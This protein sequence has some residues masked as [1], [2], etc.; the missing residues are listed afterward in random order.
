MRLEV[1]RDATAS[2][3]ATRPKPR[4]LTDQG[5]LKHRP[6]VMFDGSRGRPNAEDARYRI[7]ATAQRNGEQGSL[8]PDRQPPLITG[9]GPEACTVRQQQMPQHRVLSLEPHL[10]LDWRGRDSQDETQKPDYSGSLGDSVTSST[11]ITFSLHTGANST[12][13]TQSH[14]QMVSCWPPIAAPDFDAAPTG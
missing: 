1:D 9:R 4:L 12:R 13:M 3:P 8:V 2:E 5:C 14:H 10:R 11:R 7:R 6:A